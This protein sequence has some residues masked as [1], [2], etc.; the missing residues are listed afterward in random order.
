MDS[1]S[2]KP[3]ASNYS[4]TSP[5]GAFVAFPTEVTLQVLSYLSVRDL[6]RCTRTCTFLHS[7]VNHSPELLYRVELAAEGFVDHA[8]SDLS[9]RE[10]LNL[11]I[12]QAVAWRS[13]R[14]RK[15]TTFTT[16][17]IE[18]FHFAD[19]TFIAR[20]CV[21]IGIPERVLHIYQSSPALESGG[22]FPINL[23]LETDANVSGAYHTFDVSQDLLVLG[24]QHHL[25]NDLPRVRLRL[26]TLSSHGSSPH[27]AASQE[28]LEL[29]YNAPAPVI[30]CR[31]R[32]AGPL[33]GVGTEDATR[34]YF[35]FIWNWKT[36]DTVLDM[37]STDRAS[38]Y[39]FCFLSEYRLMLLCATASE[40]FLEI[41]SVDQ[42]SSATND[43]KVLLRLSFP[44]LGSQFFSGFS[45]SHGP[46]Q[47]DI[48][49]GTPFVK[50]SDGRIYAIVLRRHRRQVS[51]AFCFVVHHETMT[52]LLQQ[53]ETKHIP[54]DEWGPKNTRMIYRH[55]LRSEWATVING[56]ICNERLIGSVHTSYRRYEPRRLLDFNVRP[57]IRQLA[58]TPNHA[59]ASTEEAGEL[60]TEATTISLEV[61]IPEH[62]I[63]ITTSL[64]FY[65]VPI[66]LPD[67]ERRLVSI[68][69]D[70]HLV[71]TEDCRAPERDT[72][73]I[74]AFE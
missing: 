56:W 30:R 25:P 49:E 8:A 72:L 19:G 69:D 23:E 42:E 26:R 74:F 70:R 64:P 2:Q 71:F 39:D 47:S 40:L 1:S 43:S 57:Y 67:M 18:F 48:S 60:V 15:Q 3:V 17:Q 5:V 9:V 7:A 11:L 12:R 55:M 50:R 65:S 24:Y 10:R 22:A 33:L 73:D 59:G 36:G 52:A 37:D 62:T 20:P 34:G 63:A 54:W 14:W 32:I 51:P 4:K 53:K 61:G 44:D 41:R 27:P 29:S 35:V 68:M 31:F 6:L 28:T 38:L 46:F 21:S 66:N 16:P 13:L 45:L 58:M